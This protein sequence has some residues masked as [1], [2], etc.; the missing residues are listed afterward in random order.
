M[1]VT[2]ANLETLIN[3]HYQDSG[4]VSV[5]AAQRLEA[6]NEALGTLYN[7]FDFDFMNRRYRF[8]YF[9]GVNRYSLNTNAP[10]V[11]EPIGIFT[12]DDRD[13]R[14]PFHRGE[15]REL[16]DMIGGYSSENA[17]A[18]EQVGETKY[19][20][21]NHKSKYGAVS[22]HTMDDD[23]GNGTWAVDATNSDATNLTD[24]EVE[25][26]QGGGSINFD[27]DVSQSGNDRGTIE[28]STLTA[29]DLESHVNL[30]TL[31]FWLWIPETTDFT[32][33]TPYWGSSSSAYW[34][35]AVTTDAFGDAFVE[36]DWNLIS[37][38]WTDATET[39]TVD[40]AAI[41][42]LRF[43]VNYAAGY[44]DQT[45]FRIDD[46][47][48]IRPERLDFKYI[49][50]YLAKSSA[51]YQARLTATGNEPL[52]SDVY[53]QCQYYVVYK[54]VEIL[55]LMSGQFEQATVY[56]KKAEK[57]LKKLR[58]MFPST[59]IRPRRAFGVGGIGRGRRS[60]F[61]DIKRR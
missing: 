29:I 49:T 17:F 24:D 28:N 53:D 46:V 13:N 6:T 51:T 8:N 39:G 43:D 45:D 1:A 61:T 2:Q 36:D 60:A 30:S 21:V 26:K 59:K 35:A 55:Y 16:L 7:E 12:R 33:V 47:R 22:L 5:S 44:G 25:Y 54:A 23:T 27:I 15:P 14:S 18:L 34:S 50:S 32:S 56:E 38:A 10:D 48:M 3:S 41:D 37:L 40:N 57:E 19:L 20:L 58:K 4:T 42:Y 31:F 52:Y 11:K 9:D